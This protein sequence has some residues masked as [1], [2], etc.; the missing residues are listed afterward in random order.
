MNH[1]H[2]EFQT[3]NRLLNLKG[4]NYPS[5]IGDWKTFEKNNPTIAL[6]ILYIVY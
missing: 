6:N 4:M 3:L 5:K 1:I 2:K